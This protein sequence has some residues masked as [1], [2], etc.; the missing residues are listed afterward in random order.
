VVEERDDVEDGVSSGIGG[1]AGVAVAA[2]V[3]GERAEASCGE[4]DHLVA[5]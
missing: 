3:G 1:R 5:P 4:C 2:E